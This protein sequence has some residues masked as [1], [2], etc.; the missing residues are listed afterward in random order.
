MGN[1]GSQLVPLF[2]ATF[3]RAPQERDGFAWKAEGGEMWAL[4]RGLSQAS[5]SDLGE[6][7]YLLW[8]SKL[9]E[10]WGYH[11]IHMLWGMLG[12]GSNLALLENRL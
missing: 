7:P 11:N 12:V 3:Y 8:A 10:R 4:S 9:P 5:L 1:F 6:V 2:Y